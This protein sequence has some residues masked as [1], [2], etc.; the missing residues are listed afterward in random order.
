[1]A[2]RAE[3]EKDLRGR[4]AADPALAGGA[5]PWDT[6]AAAQKRL[7]G[8]FAEYRLEGFGGSRLLGI[9]GTIV[10]YGAETSKPNDVRLDEFRDSN[11]PSLENT[12]YS[13]AT[14][15]DDIEGTTLADRLKEAEEELG[16]D[17]PYVKALLGGRSPEEVARGAVS[18]T[19]LK[20]VA[21]AK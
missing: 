3:A 13:P 2:A 8:R 5:D 21:A 9:A 4:H 7:D 16:K 6:I 1:M 19:G 15:Y 20:E 10:R 17:H 14:L 12:L 18:A 11:L